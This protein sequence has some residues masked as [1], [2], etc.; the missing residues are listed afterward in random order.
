MPKNDSRRVSVL[1]LIVRAESS[2][3][4]RGVVKR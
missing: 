3:S 2:A 4:P 1:L